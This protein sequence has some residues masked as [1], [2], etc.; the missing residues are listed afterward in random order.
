MPLSITALLSWCAAAPGSGN[1][2]A[3]LPIDEAVPMFFR[4]GGSSRPADNKSG[5]PLREPRCRGSIGIST[6]ESWPS[7]DPR[8]RV[9]LFAP[10]PWTPLQLAAIDSVSSG[11]RARA[12]Q[13]NYATASLPAVNDTGLHPHADRGLPL[14]SQENA[15]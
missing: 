2:M 7:L 15:P 4:L 11:R 9:Y 1:W 8:Q 6:D 5:Y 14:A 12:L 10:R 3:N 13:F